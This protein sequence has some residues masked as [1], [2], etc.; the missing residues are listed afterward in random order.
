MSIPWW[1]IQSRWRSRHDGILNEIR[2]GFLALK[3]QGDALMATVRE[4]YEKLKAEAEAIRTEGQE[5]RAAAALAVTKLDELRA[6]VLS[7][8][9]IS[10]DQ[11]AEVSTILTSARADFDQAEA[12]LT[13]ASTDP[14]PT[15]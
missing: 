1:D 7:G 6:L 3:Q 2:G 15:P 14:Q 12:D 5:T 4:E 13:A 9:Q 10:P 11:L 8:Q